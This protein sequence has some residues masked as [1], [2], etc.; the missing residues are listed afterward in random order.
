[1]FYHFLD[2]F[3]I[4]EETLALDMIAAVGP[5]GHH[6]GTPHTQARFRTEFY[7]SALA[8]RQG[9]DL[10][11]AAGQQDTIQRAHAIWREL[12]DQ[13]EPPPLDPAIRE[14]LADYVIRRTPEVANVNLYD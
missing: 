2:G 8:D 12:L 10:W 7:Q 5:G 11:A 14:A 4:D 3:V 1:M 13:Y 6:F 9:Y